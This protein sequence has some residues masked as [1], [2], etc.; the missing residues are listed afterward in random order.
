[1]KSKVKKAMKYIYI[2]LLIAFIVNVLKTP[3][4]TG[5]NQLFPPNK[6]N[7]NIMTEKEKLDDF[8]YFYNTVSSSMPM[9]DKFKDAY[10]FNFVERK[11]YYE[12]MIKQTKNDIEFYSVMQAIVREIPSFHTDLIYPED[13]NGLYCYN[14]NKINTN[15]KYISNSTYWTEL[16][17]DYNEKNDTEYYSFLYYDGSYIFNP[18]ESDNNSFNDM[19]VNMI[20]NISV[21]E[22]IKTNLSVYNLYYDGKNKKPY[23]SR[24]VFNSKVG[25]EHDIILSSANGSTSHIKLKIDICCD[26]LFLFKDT[27][28]NKT[29]DNYKE[30][31]VCE[32][33][34]ISYIKLDSMSPYLAEETKKAIQSL[35]NN[36]VII[37]LRDNYGGDNEFAEK[38]IYPE[39]FA[40]DIKE[41][42]YSYIPCTKYNQVFTDDIFNKMVLHLKKTKSNP[43]NNMPMYRAT[44]KNIYKGKADSNKKV[45][46]L[47]SQNTGSAA[48]NFVSDMKKNNLAVIIGNNTGGEGLMYSFCEQLLPNS[49][50][51]FIYMPCGAIDYEGVDNSVYGTSPDYYT[52]S[53]I[54]LNNLYSCSNLDELCEIDNTIRFAFELFK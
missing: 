29:P 52:A 44:K 39:L 54:T 1:M 18:D 31:F 34:N 9:I 7:R 47:I 23:R 26:E 37:D 2:L 13:Q 22:Y 42:H 27:I 11:D 25:K 16:I 8:E 28:L 30:V 50:L 21:D 40:D 35:K 17:N 4:K 43:Y 53:E 48:D 33:N 3:I 24:I 5:F 12:S 41:I 6:S 15:R 32:G 46:I 10:G 14:S 36:N 49:K 51:S 38:N 45:I 20:D 19:T